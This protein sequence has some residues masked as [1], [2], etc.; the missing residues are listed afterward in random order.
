MPKGEHRLA[1]RYERWLAFALAPAESARLQAEPH[2]MGVVRDGRCC[3]AQGVDET[4][5]CMHL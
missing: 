1:Q 2:V 4:Q 5:L 3:G